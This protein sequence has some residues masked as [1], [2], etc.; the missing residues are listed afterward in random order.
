MARV[1]TTVSLPAAMIS[2]GTLI[3]EAKPKPLICMIERAAA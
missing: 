1:E 3:E 2:S